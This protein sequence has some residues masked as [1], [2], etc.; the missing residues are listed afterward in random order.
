M[1]FK[2]ANNGND[3]GFLTGQVIEYRVGASRIT[4]TPD[5]VATLISNPIVPPG[6]SREFV[7]PL[8][9]SLEAAAAA[10]SGP[11]EVRL[12]RGES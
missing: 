11:A 3:Y 2:V 1:R 10:A 7:F 5:D 12:L 8:D 4:L 6:T 9:P